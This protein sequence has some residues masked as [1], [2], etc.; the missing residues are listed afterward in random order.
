MHF[1]DWTSDQTELIEIGLLLWV[2]A[3]NNQGILP[4]LAHFRAE[5][6][7][8]VTDDV[9]TDALDELESAG[10][11]HVT[12]TLGGK[13]A[14]S[15]QVTQEGRGEAVQIGRRRT[16]WAER[17]IAVEEALLDWVGAQ[18]RAGADG[19][20]WSGFMSD[21]RGHF[22]GDPISE[23]ERDRAVENLRESG[24]LG[25]VGVSGRPRLVLAHL[26][27]QG[28]Q[29]LRSRAGVP[30]APAADASTTFITNFHGD[31]SGQVGV[32]HDISMTQ[33]N[34]VGGE[35]LLELLDAV[36]NAAAEL[37]VEDQPLAG[38]WVDTIQAE[39]TMEH[40]DPTLVRTI[41][42]RLQGLANKAG[43]QAFS[44]AVSVL[45]TRLL[46]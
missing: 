3:Q 11:V 19:G 38:T 46:G 40:P 39:A 31:V 23:D 41:L 33:S 29:L 43:S 45:V 21:P 5:Y 20:D 4:T 18:E 13:I 36:R 26:T 14:G 7:N 22:V 28:R 1:N 27:P 35:Q 6:G 32:G 10:L 12:G 17:D 25:G 30:P 15:L 37:P 24:L 2:A 9:L 16:A 34:S 8:G 44:V 42:T